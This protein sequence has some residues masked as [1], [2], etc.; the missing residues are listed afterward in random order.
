MINFFPILD[1][2][3]LK[4]LNLSN[5]FICCEGIKYFFKS[6]LPSLKKLFLKNIN[7]T[8]QSIEYLSYA[9]FP[10]LKELNLNHNPKINGIKFIS[11]K[12]FPKL[13]ILHLEDID[14]FADEYFKYLPNTNFPLSN[15]S[16]LKYYDRIELKKIYEKFFF[17]PFRI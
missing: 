16:I 13:E 3:L 14:Y 2:P 6:N 8:D 1:L 7:I 9:N 10:S 4:E 17:F 15:E 11:Q 12:N 5:N